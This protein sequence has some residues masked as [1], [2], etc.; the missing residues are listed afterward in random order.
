MAQT[1]TTVRSY[2]RFSLETGTAFPPGRDSRGRKQNEE[3]EDDRS[4]VVGVTWVEASAFCKWTGMRLPTEAEWEYAARAGTT[5]PRYGNLNEIA[6]YGD[7]SGD[8]PI[9]SAIIWRNPQTAGDAIFANG[10]IAKPVGQKQPNAWKLY[11]MIGNVAQWT[12]DPFSNYSPDA[13]PPPR[14][15]AEARMTR[16]GTFTQPANR[17]TASKRS[18]LPQVQRNSVTGFRCAGD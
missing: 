7:N 16:G 14:G 5:G 4:P 9:D 2:R 6:W 17:A 12:A 18:Y 15:A 8:K 3:A 1:L 11:D 10:N 13:S